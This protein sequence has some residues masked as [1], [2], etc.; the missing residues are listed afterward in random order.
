MHDGKRTHPVEVEL[1]ERS[2]ST[3]TA[4]FTESTTMWLP[5][6]LVVVLLAAGVHAE[7]LQPQIPSVHLFYPDELGHVFTL[8]PETQIFVDEAFAFDCGPHSNGPTLLDF[9]ETFRSDLVHLTSFTLPPVQVTPLNQTHIDGGCSVIVLTLSSPSNHTLYSGIP[10]PEAYD[11]LVSNSSYIIHGSGSI[12][13]WWGTRTL[14][15]QLALSKQGYNGTYTIPAG[16]GTDSPGWEVR[17]FMLD[18]GRHWYT[19][20]FLGRYLFMQANTSYQSIF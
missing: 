17:G 16:N 9:A 2:D 5:R 3:L 10:T 15:Q 7:V 1:E 18:A 19:T 8:G 14:L 20:E 6:I 11:F 13:A 4:E 12:G